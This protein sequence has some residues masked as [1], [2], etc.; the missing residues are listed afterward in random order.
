MFF[1][2][3]HAYACKSSLFISTVESKEQNKLTKWRQTQEYREET[4]SCER[5]GGYWLSEKGE[6]IKQRKKRKT[7]GHRQPTSNT[8][9]YS[10]LVGALDSAFLINILVIL[11]SSMLE[12]F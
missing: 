4:D 6:G 11:C 2:I 12:K 9:V 5:G 7:H 1:K 8:K 10:K 3:I